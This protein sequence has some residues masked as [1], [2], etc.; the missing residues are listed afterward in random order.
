MKKEIYDKMDMCFS[1]LIGCLLIECIILFFMK[2]LFL[3]IIGLLFILILSYNI[4][5][6]KERVGG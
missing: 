1:F 6:S 2:R 3:V 4:R 5:H